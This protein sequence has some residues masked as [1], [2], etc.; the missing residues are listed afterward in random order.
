[1]SS[2][3][4]QQGLNLGDA[5]RLGQ[6]A[7]RSGG[8]TARAGSPSVI[9]SLWVKRCRLHPTPR[10]GPRCWRGQR[11]LSPAVTV[12]DALPGSPRNQRSCPAQRHSNQPVRG[13]RD[14]RRS[15][16][17]H[18][19]KH[20]RVLGDASFHGEVIQERADG[21][22]RRR[23]GAQFSTSAR[24]RADRPWAPATGALVGD[25]S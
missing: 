5:E 7:R 24:S 14:S 18:A 13:R 16:L 12:W 25:P 20:G 17:G 21:D 2:R 8:V 11:R 9:P 10:L 1:M 3:G 15:A 22:L 4:I 23:H 19:G 6:P